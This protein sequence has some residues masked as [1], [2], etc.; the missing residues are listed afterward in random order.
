MRF[1]RYETLREIASGGMATV[2]LGRAMGAGGFERLVAIKVM[3]PHIAKQPEFIAM[4]LDEA[5]LAAGIRHPNVVD[6]IDV[7]QDDDGLFLVMDYVEGPSLAQILRR[8]GKEDEQIPLE[9]GLR[10]IIDALSGLH[11]AHE[12]RDGK[13]KL[14]QL[15][16]RD[17]S[18]ANVL[19]GVDGVTRITDFGVARAEARL[20]VTTDGRVKGK[21]AYMAPEQACGDV[22]D[23]RADV[24][25][26][27]VVLWEV[28]VGKRL[29]QAEHESRLVAMILAG[30]DE[31]PRQ[32]NESVPEAIDNI[33]MTALELDHDK[34]H[35][36]AQVFLDELEKAAAATNIT[37][38][39][40]RRVAEYV[41]E[42]QSLEP[43]P[44]YANAELLTELSTG[45]AREAKRLANE[46]ETRSEE[47]SAA[48][49]VLTPP[50]AQ[51]SRAAW[52]AAISLLVIGGGAAVVYAPSGGPAPAEPERAAASPADPSTPLLAAS[53]SAG[54]A[55]AEASG[56]TTAAAG[57]VP[58]AGSSATAA[59]S[60]QA[61]A[62][63]V[64]QARPP[65]YRP[66]QGRPPARTNPSPTSFNPEEP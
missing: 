4:F 23:R 37:I 30:V 15:V 24:Y 6:T 57:P 20:G 58:A 35:A 32:H 44:S 36:T 50:P 42:F 14:Q 2:H 53:A 31:S 60:T 49:A 9:V 65:T 33:C 10:I 5:R 54:T 63:P 7:H 61:P 12:L 39:S 28:L 55:S 29:M 43:P 38:A 40:T 21:L 59:A 17:V 26:A 66:P 25:A 52:L 51:R 34:R 46:A 1:G 62:V 22:V 3:H 18:P 13:G 45:S 47:V 56:S 27:G 64:T 8:L 41:E 16:H 48:N 11:A 19:V